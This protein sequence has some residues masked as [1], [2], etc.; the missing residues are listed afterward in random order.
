MRR[1]Y[2]SLPHF[3]EA[4][5][6]LQTRSRTSTNAHQGRRL[7]TRTLENFQVWI[8]S[9]MCSK[10][11]QTTSNCGSL[12]KTQS[13]ATSFFTDYSLISYSQDLRR[14]T[15]P[16][17]IRDMLPLLVR[18]ARHNQVNLHCHHR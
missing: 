1:S 12:A 13:A 11:F 14:V 16:P 5:S 15:T 4:W 18:A 3:Q 9:K 8:T 17:L 10:N 7:Q 2:K 6:S